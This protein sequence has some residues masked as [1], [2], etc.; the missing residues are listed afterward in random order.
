MGVQVMGAYLTVDDT[1]AT[2]QSVSIMRKWFRMSTAR[3]LVCSNSS[4]RFTKSVFG[5][6]KH[7][8]QGQI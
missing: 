6:A 5:L 7:I 2:T 4:R 8:I 1:L 3:C